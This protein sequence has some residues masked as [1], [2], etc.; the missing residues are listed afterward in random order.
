MG[1]VCVW[2]VV[3][4]VLSYNASIINLAARIENFQKIGPGYSPKSPYG[5]AAPDLRYTHVTSISS[6]CIRV[7][8]LASTL[9]AHRAK[10]PNLVNH[11]N[12]NYLTCVPIIA[13]GTEKPKLQVCN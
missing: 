2:C 4:V 8:A 3:V 6:A 5:V 1:F 9:C 10:T 12:N 11:A 13:G 7:N